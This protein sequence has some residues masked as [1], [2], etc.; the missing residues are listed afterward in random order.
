M[1]RCRWGKQTCKQSKR[2]SNALTKRAG[3]APQPTCLHVELPLPAGK[4]GERKAGKEVSNAAGAAAWAAAAAWRAADSK[5]L[6]AREVTC[7]ATA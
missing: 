1:G 7:A 5:R 2:R 4:S 3:L 6:S